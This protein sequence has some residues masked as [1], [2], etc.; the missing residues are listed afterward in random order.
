MSLGRERL[1]HRQGERLCL[2]LAYCFNVTQLFPRGK[3]V[4]P[5]TFEGGERTASAF[6]YWATR[7]VPNKNKKLYHLEDIEP[8]VTK[9]RSM[10]LIC[11]A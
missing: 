9:A 3:D 1:P 5:I 6:Y 10:L 7:R 4:K 8:W 2:V 11:T